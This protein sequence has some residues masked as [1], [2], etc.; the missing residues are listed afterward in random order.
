VLVGDGADLKNK[1]MDVMVYFLL[2]PEPEPE[3]SSNFRVPEPSLKDIFLICARY[4]NFPI[5]QNSP[6]LAENWK[7]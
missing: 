4:P 6:I 7:N 1:L 2:E 3:L 5:L